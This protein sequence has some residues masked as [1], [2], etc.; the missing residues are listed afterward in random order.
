MYYTIM[1]AAI[2]ILVA[3]SAFFS[4]ME[5]ATNSVSR[6]RLLDMNEKGI[7]GSKKALVML[8]KY[9]KTIT[10]LL[11]GNNIVN[12]GA[13]SLAT[14][15]CT[16]LIGDYGAAVSTGVLTLI[17]LTFGEV[18]P[19]CYAKENSEKM[20]VRFSGIVYFLMVVLT[21]LSFLFLKLNAFALKLVGGGRDTPSVTEDEL[22]Y[23]IESIEE[24]GVLEEAESEMVQ[25]AL[26]F[27]EKTVAV[28]LTPRVDVVAI[29][30]DDPPEEIRRVIREERFSRIPVY[31]D[32]IDNIIGILHT[33]DYL[34]AIIDGK[35]PDLKELLQK[36][37]FVYKKRKLAAMFSDF[38]RMHTHIAI[39]ADEYGGMLGI[40]TMEDLLE[41]LVG[42]IWDED[43][44]IEL[45]CRRIGEDCYEIS[46]DMPLEDVLE[47]FGISE[48]D[49]ET[50]SRSVGG[51]VTEILGSIP[52]KGQKISVS[53]L[54]VKVADIS[55]QR[56]N[57]LLIKKSKD[58]DA[59]K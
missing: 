27:D 53:G 3:L 50:T 22:K 30:I 25:S 24:E 6:A 32:T 21:P 9:D 36:P 5:T 41:E 48:K 13:S 42:E 16:A 33:R 39:V 8:D 40:V 34:E 56:V 49:V 15:L 18:I 2:A 44:E 55:E 31:K 7:R 12:I 1:T 26:E 37:F 20:L 28:I 58:A 10:T 17:I 4:S 59:E 11:I 57:K 19:K 54:D 43:E 14:V 46:G 52:E 47:L 45:H 51:W 23:I 38:K 35:S 29:D